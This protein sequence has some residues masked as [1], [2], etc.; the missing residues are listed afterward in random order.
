MLSPGGNYAGS[1]NRLRKGEA[2]GKCFGGQRA[3][4]LWKPQ[5]DRW[6]ATSSVIPRTCFNRCV[7]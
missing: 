7:I 5:V 2:V 3:R 4:N 6:G 1:C